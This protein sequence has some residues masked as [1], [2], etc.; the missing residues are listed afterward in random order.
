MIWEVESGALLSSLFA[1][2]GTSAAAEFPHLETAWERVAG[3]G[4]A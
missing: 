2:A 1:A 4:S 3:A